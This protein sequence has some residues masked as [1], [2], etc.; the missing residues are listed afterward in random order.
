VL[1]VK[2]YATLREIVGQKSVDFPLN[3]GDTVNELMNKIIDRYPAL[4]PKLLDEDGE[5]LGYVHFFVNG[6]DLPYLEKGMETELSDDDTI[7][8]FPAV[9]GGK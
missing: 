3:E 6:R 2:F 5:L 8:V 7:S 9:G 4:E 1:K